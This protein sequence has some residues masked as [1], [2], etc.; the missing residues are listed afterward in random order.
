MDLELAGST[1][2]ITGASRGIGR[3]T[4]SVLAREG[5]DLILTARDGRALH[6]L[7][8]SLRR[9]HGTCV[10]VHP[11]DLRDPAAV[12]QLSAA[13]GN[14]DV[15][16]NNAGDIPAGSLQAIDREAWLHGWQLKV[17]G[18]IDLTRRIYPHLQARGGGV[19]VNNIGA[20]GERSDPDYI[21][22]GTGNA[23]LMAFTRTLGARSLADNIRVVGVNPGP[24]ATDR[25]TSLMRGI[26]DARYGDAERYLELF[27]RFPGGRAAEPAEIADAIAF[28][29]SPRSGY[30]SGTVLTI[31]GGVSAGGSF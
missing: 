14:I 1:A 4:A 7:A 2:L 9:D 3:A 11:A 16:V 24:V 10:A 6:E 17:I 26:A 30:T 13:A 28:L 18:Y 5:C 20:S 12:Q 29:A 19:I 23:A 8:G 25:I 21:A 27:D 15:L 31:D 22:G